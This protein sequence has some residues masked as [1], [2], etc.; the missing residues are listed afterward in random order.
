[1]PKIKVVSNKIAESEKA[2]LFEVEYIGRT[3]NAD[4]A[5]KTKELWFPKSQVNIEGDEPDFTLWIIQK[6]EEEIAKDEG[7]DTVEIPLKG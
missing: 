2:L 4:T 1:M 7:Y 6:K 3:N 5:R